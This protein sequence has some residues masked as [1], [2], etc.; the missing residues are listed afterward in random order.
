MDTN[1]RLLD[2][3]DCLL[4]N[5]PREFS[6]NKYR[7]NNGNQHLSI[8]SIRKCIVEISVVAHSLKLSFPLLSLFESG[9]KVVPL[10]LLPFSFLF[11]LWKKNAMA[12][13][14]SSS[15]GWAGSFAC[16]HLT[17]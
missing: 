11:L 13:K 10:L 4:L 1:G 6:L 9:A 2:S 15:A 17:A 12:Q 7:A 3:K 5:I 14:D 16:C 8:F